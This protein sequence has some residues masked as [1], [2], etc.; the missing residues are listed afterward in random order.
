MIPRL[1]PGSHMRDPAPAGIADSPARLGRVGRNPHND[2]LFLQGK[3]PIYASRAH[4]PTHD[5]T[6]HITLTL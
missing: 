5:P 6:C 1:L 2:L 3:L 4:D